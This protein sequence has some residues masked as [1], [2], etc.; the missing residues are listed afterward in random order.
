MRQVSAFAGF[1]A[2]DYYVVYDELEDEVDRLTD[3][4]AEEAMRGET[5]T[6]GERGR[7]QQQHNPDRDN[8]KS[9]LKK[10]GR[11]REVGIPKILRAL[12]Y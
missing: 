9:L 7:Q 2:D 6:D 1:E 3:E 4:G 10:P 11:G 8:L 5:G 12:S